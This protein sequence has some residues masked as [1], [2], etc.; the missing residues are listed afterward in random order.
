MNRKVINNLSLPRDKH[1]YYYFLFSTC[2]R[3]SIT[4]I[5]LPC[6]LC[7]QIYKM[8]E[9]FYGPTAK[10]THISLSNDKTMGWNLLNLQYNL[11]TRI[12]KGIH[13]DCIRMFWNDSKQLSIFF[14]LSVK[15][16]KLIF[17]F[18]IFFSLKV[19]FSK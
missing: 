11:S 15:V 17:L 9:Y 19:L 1:E 3:T 6:L 18:R 14:F 2:F 16:Q 7:I 8:Y 5:H 10:I 12:L 4:K 13:P